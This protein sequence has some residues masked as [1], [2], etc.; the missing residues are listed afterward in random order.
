MPGM[1]N[2]AMP[3]LTANEDA[4]RIQ[5]IW[6]G[7]VLVSTIAVFFGVFQEHGIWSNPEVQKVADLS[8]AGALRDAAGAAAW[9]SHEQQHQ[10]GGGDGGEAALLQSTLEELRMQSAMQTQVL[11]AQ[12]SAL[13]ALNRQVVAQS[14][15]L[16]RT[17][18][19]I[20][21]AHIELHTHAQQVCSRSSRTYPGPCGETD[22]RNG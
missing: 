8:G 2:N 7:F 18:E 10:A 21:V 22:A 17:T 3:P 9:R 11:N 1:S 4:W 6:P 20:D 15:A 13:E 5:L 19:K 14:E 12:I 16:T